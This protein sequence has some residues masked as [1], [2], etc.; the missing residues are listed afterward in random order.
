MSNQAK[1]CR[2]ILDFKEIVTNQVFTS[3]QSTLITRGASQE[4]TSK[5]YEDVKTV[6]DQNFNN[7]VDQVIKL[8]E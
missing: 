3:V 1:I 4:E 5:V 8:T 7:I 2:T 6:V